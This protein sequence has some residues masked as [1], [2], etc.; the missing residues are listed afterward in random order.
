[1]SDTSVIPTNITKE[2]EN[3]YIDYAIS[4]LTDRA[5][6]DIRDG[7]KPSQRRIIL[8][9]K[10]LK[11]GAKA[12]HRKCALVAGYVSGNYHPHGEAV[13]Y[14]TMVRMAQ[15]FSL[16]YPLVDG[17]GNFGNIGGSPPA[18]MRYTESRMSVAAEDLIDD[19][20]IDNQWTIPITKNYD[21]TKDEPTVLPSRFPNLLV[22]GSDGIAVGWAT[23]IPPHNIKEISAG[24]IAMI[25]NKELSDD[26]LLSYVSGPDFP[27][28]GIIH[29]TAGTHQLYTTGSGHLVVT[30][31]VK[32]ENKKGGTAT[33][34]VYELPY[35]VTT[36]TF[37]DYADDA[38]KKGRLSGI[39]TLKDAS[40]ERMGHPIQVIFYLKRGEDPQ[41]VLNQLYE[42]TPLKT[43]YAGNMIALVEGK[44]GD[45]IPS[46]TP[47]NLRSMMR[48]WIQFRAEVVTKRIMIQLQTA[49]K[50]ILRLTALLTATDPNNIDKVI[51]TI[52]EGADE[53]EVISRLMTLLVLTEPQ[54]RDILEITLRRLMKLERSSL[55]NQLDQ[56]NEFVKGAEAVLQD[57]KLV[58]DIIIGELKD[59][60]KSY[61]DARRTS[62]E[63]EMKKLATGDLVPEEQVIVT[64]T[65]TG[66]IK[67]SPLESYRKTSRGTKGVI[68]ATTNDDDYIVKVF[69]AST[70][71]WLLAFT[72][73]GM[74]HW[75]KVFDIPESVRVAK[76]RA[77]VNLI[78][79]QEGEK[80][81]SIIPVSGE[82]DQREIVFGTA[83][84]L[85]K[86]THLA[87]YGNP[88]NGGIV[89]IK[90]N[91]DDKLVGATLTDGNNQLL[92]I[93][94]GG[95]AIRVEEA[96]IASQGRNT[97]GRRGIKL[98]LFGDKVCALLCI[99]KEDQRFVLTFTQEGVGK[100]T[101]ISEYPAHHCGGSGVITSIVAGPETH[102]VTAAL[103][104]EA[105]GV[106]IVSDQGKA[107]RIPVKEIRISDRRTKGVRLIDLDEGQKLVSAAVITKED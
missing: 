26:E 97:A 45:R 21:E 72:N 35:G 79:L 8:S 87:E 1:M 73:L 18:A 32:I 44:D 22:N 20:K 50:E 24:L 19:L 5:I 90:L 68:G 11:V 6:P 64:L 99:A 27:T 107:V 41:V 81:T 84:G 31:R 36:D 2:I 59:V 89:A 92:L 96:E 106:M 74:V 55:Q 82:F 67:R 78:K 83:L 17:Q 75:L 15:S 42:H 86:K 23:S 48:A 43:T 60:E 33:I 46:K 102:I 69:P 34:T 95:Q 49:R 10:D 37:L 13:V 54:I 66:Y 7:L 100:R 103:V 94:E 57:P 25:R 101:P 47:L 98:K 105:D 88:R 63:G 85:V 14:P 80:V 3:S 104:N 30:G 52:K 70:H 61:G 9:L 40:S 77:L 65:N 39:S 12:K 53:S 62:I 38:F 4:V 71:D 28:G 93:T 51:T 58:D 76:G 16:R 29:G 56:R 91:D